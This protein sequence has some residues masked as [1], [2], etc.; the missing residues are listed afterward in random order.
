MYST[1]GEKHSEK[2]FIKSGI[3]S[4]PEGGSGVSIESVELPLSM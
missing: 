1:T 4:R 3:S 2:E